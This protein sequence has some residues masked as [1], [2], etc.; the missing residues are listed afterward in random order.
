MQALGE[1]R[2][3]RTDA[4]GDGFLTAA[5]LEAAGSEKAQKRSARMIERLDVDKDGK[6]SLDEMKNPRRDPARLFERLDTDKSGGIS[7]AEFQEAK[8]HRKKGRHGDK[9]KHD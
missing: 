3:T 7:E 2:F 5:E 6:L 4:D 9:P 1:A 8:A